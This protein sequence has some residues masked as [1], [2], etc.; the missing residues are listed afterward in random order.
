MEERR[1]VANGSI[2]PDLAIGA[3]TRRRGRGTLRKRGRRGK[4]KVFAYRLSGKLLGFSG[5]DWA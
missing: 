2:Q 4:E 1:G 3:S 5:S